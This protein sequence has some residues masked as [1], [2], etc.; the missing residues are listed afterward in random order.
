[1]CVALKPERTALS[2]AA[3]AFK[4]VER[5]VKVEVVAAEKLVNGGAFMTSALRP[6]LEDA[7]E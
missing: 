1:L 4:D 2:P 6:N 5:R 3:E 7:H